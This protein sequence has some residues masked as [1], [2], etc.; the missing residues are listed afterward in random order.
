MISTG[1]I[2]ACDDICM[3]ESVHEQ[4]RKEIY[5]LYETCETLSQQRKD[6]ESFGLFTEAKEEYFTESVAEVIEKIGEKILAIIQKFKD[7]MSDIFR[8]WKERNWEKKDDVQKLRDIERKNPDIAKKVSIAVSKGDLDMNSFK[9]M[10]DFFKNVDSVLDELKKKD[11]P[12]DSLKAKI[13][14]CKDGLVK[15]ESTVKAV[16][17]VLGVVTA[18]TGLVLFYPKFKTATGDYLLKQADYEKAEAENR[19]KRLQMEYDIIQEKAKTNG[20][21]VSEYAGS[22]AALLAD[23]SNTISQQTCTH[24]NK[25]SALYRKFSVGFLTRFRTITKTAKTDNKLFVDELKKRDAEIKRLNSVIK[26]A[27]GYTPKNP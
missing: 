15:N 5:N 1:F 23:L 20:P 19:L 18:A 2:H 8:K 14:K 24:V 9:D 21:T 10:N 12:P 27:E 3:L 13:Q 26:N 6:L 7:T 22:R 17:S 16:A 4:N 25:L 11:V